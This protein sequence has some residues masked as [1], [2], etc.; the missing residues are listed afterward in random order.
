VRFYRIQI[1]NA[2]TGA[3]IIPASLGNLG[4]TSLLPSGAP[5]PAALLIEMDIPVGPFHAPIGGAWVRIWGIG[6]QQIGRAFDLNGALIK[7]YGGMSKGLPLANPSQANLL[8]SGRI[9]QAFG[10]W[11]GPDQ[12]I[13]LLITPAAGTVDQPLNFV[14]N[15]RAGMP[16]SDALAATLKTALPNAIQKISVS[17]RLVANHDQ[18]GYYQ[19]LNQ[20][21]EVVYNLS[22]AVVTDTTYPG[23]VIGYDGVTVKATDETVKPAPTA[24]DFKDLIG[25][26]TWIGFNTISVKTV[27]RGDLFLQDVVTLPRSAV[28]TTAASASQFRNDPKNQSTFSGN[29]VIQTIHH[30]GN[31]RQPDAA[32]WTSVYEMTPQA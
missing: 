28:T 22:K 6:L 8:V 32:S 23:V 14:L 3:P 29:F 24:I 11:A 26:P 4:I 15:W 13:D 2:E 20:L 7:V 1:E 17:P 18:P 5:N 30:F 16:L 25:Q 31:S 9:N 27:M 19:T 10:N 12:S 21:A